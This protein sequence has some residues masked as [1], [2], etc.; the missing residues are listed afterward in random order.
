MI[1]SSTCHWWSSHIIIPIRQAYE[2]LHL[3]P[4]IDDL[5]YPVM[6]AGVGRCGGDWSTAVAVE[7]VNRIRQKMK[8]AQDK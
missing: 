2:W 7:Q 6:L 1:G 4:C 3:K 5:S 8:T